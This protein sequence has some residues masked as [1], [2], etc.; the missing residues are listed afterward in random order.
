MGALHSNAQHIIPEAI[1]REA[2]LALAFYPE[3]RNTAIEFRFK[4]KTGKSTMQA[5]PVFASLLQARE[6]RRYL[7]F[8]SESIK[9]TGKTF[10]TTDMDSAILI[11]WLGHELGHIM[12]Y[13]RRSSLNLVWFGLKYLFSGNFIKEAER[14]ADSYAV[15]AGMEAYI[16]KTKAFI[17]DNAEID[18]KY[19]KRIRKYYL[20]PD[21]IMVLVK[22]RQEGNSLF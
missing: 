10:K 16:L 3:L 4:R 2:R 20:S 17:L 19:K 9:I 13:E 12:D 1:D 14:A 11:G 8:V 7:V 5:Q 22:Q 21:E 18:P 6:R 15:G